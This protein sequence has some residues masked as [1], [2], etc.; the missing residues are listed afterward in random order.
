MSSRHWSTIVILILV[1]DHINYI[2]SFRAKCEASWEVTEH[3]SA[4]K[5]I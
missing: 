1:N 5:L 2:I 3:W 4:S